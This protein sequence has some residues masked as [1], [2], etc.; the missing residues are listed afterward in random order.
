MEIKQNPFSFYD[1]LGYL[2]PGSIFLYGVIAG[3]A[4][5][6]SE[7]SPYAF[8]VKELSFEKAE[9]YIPFI[10][11]AYIIG[12]ILSFLSS[13]IVE[14]YSIWSD[15]Y[16]SKYL[17]GFAS[18]GYFDVASHKWL[19]IS[20]RGG[21]GL[22]LLP[23]SF[24]DLFIGH[25]A[26]FRDL[27]AKSLDGLLVRVIKNKLNAL[28]FEHAGLTTAPKNVNPPEADYF[29]Y[30]YHYVVENA[31]N[32][33]PKM[34][35]YVALYGFL[36]TLTMLSVVFFWGMVWHIYKVQ[37]QP[38][39][40]VLWVLISALIAYVLYM[41]FVK[42]YRRFSLEALMALAATYKLSSEMIDWLNEQNAKHE[43]RD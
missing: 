5:V 17:L 6:Y 2:T 1:F 3:Y 42:F 8:V 40:A 28:L 34:Q 23:I 38:I 25:G 41:S 4:H 12:H 20:I 24:F 31:P 7:L 13:V 37:M 22:F 35:N 27:Y 19:R 26:K 18:K 30:A 9:I 14:R 39:Q 16:P 33:L 29:R 43:E 36:R 15:G 10:F 32:H 11:V 21:V